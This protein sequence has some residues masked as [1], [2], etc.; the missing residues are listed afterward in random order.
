MHTFA[1]ET[2]AM[3]FLF[4]LLLSGSIAFGQQSDPNFLK[5]FEELMNGKPEKSLK[6]FSKVLKKDPKNAKALMFT[7]S[8]KSLLGNDSEAL[9]DLNRSIA[10]D[11]SI[12]ETY[13]Y[14]SLIKYGANDF[15]GAIEDV[16]VAINLDTQNTGYIY[17]RAKFNYELGNYIG[18]I[19]DGEAILK[20]DQASSNPY[21]LFYMAQAY[22]ELN[23]FMPALNLANEFILFDKSVTGYI[24][25]GDIHYKMGNY[26]IAADD[27]EIYITD[28]DPN[29]N[30]GEAYMKI[31]TTYLKL[32]KTEKACDSFNSAKEFGI[33]ID[34]NLMKA[35][36]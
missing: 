17:N 10:I 15:K 9:I 20:L 14:R 22:A 1:P 28:N 30:R 34:Q 12:G 33:D 26:A 16:S 3:K 32:R 29:L 2:N 21:I 13:H 23:E 6:T 35:C 8:I 4:T 19:K 5:G 7:G 24:L 18:T 31:G 36:N 27:Y 25:R 11:P